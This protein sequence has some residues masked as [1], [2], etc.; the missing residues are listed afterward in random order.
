MRRRHT[1]IGEAGRP[2][3]FTVPPLIQR[4]HP[5]VVPD[6]LG[7]TLHKPPLVHV[8]VQRQK[9]A[10]VTSVVNERQRGVGAVKKTLLYPPSDSKRSFRI[11]S[12]PFHSLFPIGTNV[13]MRV[14]FWRTVLNKP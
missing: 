13:L 8:T 10:S 12:R 2:A 7:E 14:K 1:V 4:D 11:R 6:R 5:V 3:G 9:R